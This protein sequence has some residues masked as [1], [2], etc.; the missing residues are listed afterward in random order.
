MAKGSGTTKTVGSSSAGAARTH[1]LSE[2]QEYYSKQRAG[3]LKA[4][5]NGD[6]T[7]EQYDNRIIQ[8]AKREKKNTG[9][10]TIPTD[11]RKSI[12]NRLMNDIKHLNSVTS[13][14][15]V[16]GVLDRASENY[17]NGVLSTIQYNRIYKAGEK[18]IGELSKKNK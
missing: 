5:A 14:T 6:L 16:R 3:A 15:E 18:K 1:S 17:E 10:A 13:I 4:L 9:E 7:R 8:I 2:Y 11:V 12:E